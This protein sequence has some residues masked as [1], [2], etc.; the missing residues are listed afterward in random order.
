VAPGSAVYARFGVR[1]QSAQSCRLPSPAPNCSRP[2]AAQRRQLGRLGPDRARR[3]WRYTA[4]K[5]PSPARRLDQPVRLVRPQEPALSNSRLFLARIAGAHGL[6]T[7]LLPC[8]KLR[9]SRYYTNSTE[10]VHGARI[11]VPAALASSCSNSFPFGSPSAGPDAS[12]RQFCFRKR[13]KQRPPGEAK[14]RPVNPREV[15]LDIRNITERGRRDVAPDAA[16]L[17]RA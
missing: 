17:A 16:P 2:R 11:G 12:D 10:H 6:Q 7:P 14:E 8:A 15:N 5:A 4:R 9:Y 13:P 1:S 3:P